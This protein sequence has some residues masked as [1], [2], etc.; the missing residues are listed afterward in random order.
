MPLRVGI[1]GFGRIGK[2]VFRII[3]DL[4][5]NNGD[6]Q[7][8]AINCP[9]CTSINL[10]YLINYDS[11]HK[12]DKYQIDV[13]DNHIMVNGNK[14]MLFR[15]R[16]PSKIDWDKADVNYVID[17]TGVFKNMNSASAH[18]SSA[19]VKKI[20]ITVASE[21]VPMYVVGVNSNKY[22]LSQKIV[23]NSSCT[24]NCLAPIA[25]V[26]NDYVGIEK[27][28][29]STIHSITS[30]QNTLDGKSYKNIR[31]GRSSN[32]IIPSTTSATKALGIVLPE[33][34]NKI[35]GLSYRVPTNNVSII[36][37]SFITK[38]ETTCQK[39][40]EKLKHESENSMKGIISCTNE[41]LVSSDYFGNSHSAIV[42]INLCKEIGTNFFKIVAWYDNEWG[43]SCRVVDLLRI[44]TE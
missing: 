11:V 3:E 42:D 18:F 6:F 2:L 5:L 1:S 15:E 21:D 25:K 33:L 31:I 29:V 44:I 39:L 30:S 32:N 40:I 7:I 28:F 24:T 37:F 35:S 22:D 9:S 4:R 34:N 13:F 19:G 26:I 12:L 36:D 17:S 16:D 38:K 14:I 20:I 27:G 8:A 41:E 43:Y 10:K 23:S